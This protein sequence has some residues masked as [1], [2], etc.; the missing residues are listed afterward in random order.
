MKRLITFSLLFLGCL[1][2]LVGH[3]QAQ[4]EEPAKPKKFANA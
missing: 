1:P 2:L 4:G 3:I